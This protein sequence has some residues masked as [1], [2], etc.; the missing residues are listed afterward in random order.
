[1]EVN[2]L[3][4]ADIITAIINPLNPDGKENKN[5]IQYV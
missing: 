4:K 5:L 1:M 2:E 3:I